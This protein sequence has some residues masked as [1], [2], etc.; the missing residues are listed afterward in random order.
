MTQIMHVRSHEKAPIFFHYLNE[1]L[2]DFMSINYDECNE[3][4]KSYA[5]TTQ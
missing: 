5:H 3:R 4:K 1:Y 2:L